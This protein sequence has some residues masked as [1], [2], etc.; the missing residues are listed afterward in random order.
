[1]KK[2]ILLLICPIVLLTVGVGIYF[3]LNRELVYD[4]SAQSWQKN[5]S[6]YLGTFSAETVNN[7]SFIPKNSQEF[8][9]QAESSEAF[10]GSRNYPCLGI[11]DNECRMFY[12]DDGIY[13]LMFWGDNL[14]ELLACKTNFSAYRAA[15]RNYAYPSP[16]EFYPKWEGDCYTPE[17][18][19]WD[20]DYVFGTFE[21]AVEQFYGYFSE[22]VVSIDTENRIIRCHPYCYNTEQLDSGKWVIIDFTTK[23]VGFDF[24]E[25]E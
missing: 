10:I 20:F 5:G 21:E 17:N 12:Y 24:G 15:A 23:T 14:Y 13:A 11:A 9:R 7:S 2:R 25:E 4:V 6:F 19:Y 22:A 1:M 8:I 16:G 18:D 3:W